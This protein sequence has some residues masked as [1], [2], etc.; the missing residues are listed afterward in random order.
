MQIPKNR[1]TSEEIQT[2]TLHSQPPP[3]SQTRKHIPGCH[4]LL[5]QIFSVCLVCSPILSQK[6]TQIYAD[7]T[8][9][10]RIWSVLCYSWTV[11]LKQISHSHSVHLNHFN[12]PLWKMVAAHRGC[13]LSKDTG[14]RTSLLTAVEKTQPQL[15]LWIICAV[16]LITKC[17]AAQLD[18]FLFLCNAP[19]PKMSPGL[20][21]LLSH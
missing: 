12:Q 3:H 5:M 10:L 11:D 7:T 16:D 8:K 1:H 17:D 2:F 14:I 19:Y 15:Q 18:Y 20:S 9:S 13:V 4:F 21:M 6:T